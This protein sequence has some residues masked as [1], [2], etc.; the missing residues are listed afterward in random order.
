[1][2]RGGQQRRHGREQEAAAEQPNLPFAAQPRGE[3]GQARADDQQHGSGRHQILIA[4]ADEGQRRVGRFGGMIGEHR[5]RRLDGGLTSLAQRLGVG[6]GGLAAGDVV[7]G[8]GGQT[9]ETR[10]IA[11][12]GHRRVRY[13]GGERLEGGGLVQRLSGFDEGL[14]GAQRFL[15]GLFGA[16]RV[17]LGR[18]QRGDEVSVGHRAEALV[19]RGHVLAGLLRVQNGLT[20]RAHVGFGVVVAVLRGLPGVCRRGYAVLRLAQRVGRALV[21]A[22]QR[23]LRGGDGGREALRLLTMLLRLSVG[24][25]QRRARPVDHAAGNAGEDQQCGQNQHNR[26]KDAALGEFHGRT[27]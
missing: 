3:E 11:Q 27:S 23:F 17:G 14:K 20:Q 8:S 15:V 13:L 6:Y 25:G 9:V 16:A 18:V 7:I 19:D 5:L 24:R 22:V 12:L 1:M 2:Q 4:G 10:P 26:A 21:G